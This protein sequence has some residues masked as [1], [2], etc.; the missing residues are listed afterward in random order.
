MLYF[1]KRSDV[2]DSHDRYANIEIN[3]LLQRI[4]TFTG[5]AILATN[6]KDALDN[7]FVRRLRFI[8]NFPFPSQQYR[9][10]IWQRVFPPTVPCDLLDL[11]QLSALNLTGGSIHAT[12]LNATFLAAADNSPVTMSHILMAAQGEYRKLDLPIM[13]GQFRVRES[14]R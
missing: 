1:G 10:H 2:K 3:Y 6:M 8:V 5:L 4:E 9:Y 11:Q 12:A 13:D 14:Q 7:A